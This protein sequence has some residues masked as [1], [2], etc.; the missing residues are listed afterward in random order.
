V[1]VLC[2]LFLHPFEIKGVWNAEVSI[3]SS[4]ELWEI[5]IVRT[6]VGGG[7]DRLFGRPEDGIHVVAWSS[8]F[9]GYVFL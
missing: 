3:K 6:L 9:L 2:R 5:G 8:P 1:S 4:E 7:G